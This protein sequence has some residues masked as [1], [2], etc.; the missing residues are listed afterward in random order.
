MTLTAA[1]F[2]MFLAA[3]CPEHSDGRDKCSIKTID[4]P[5]QYTV[6]INKGDQNY[7]IKVGNGFSN[8]RFII[9]SVREIKKDG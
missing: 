3:M 2:L 6:V 9:K 1:A 8:T 7:Y 4:H 5:A